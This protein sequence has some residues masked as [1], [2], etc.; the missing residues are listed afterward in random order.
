MAAFGKNEDHRPALIIQICTAR[1]SSGSN[2]SAISLI[3]SIE[4]IFGGVTVVFLG[5]VVHQ[6]KVEMILTCYLL[7]ERVAAIEK[8]IPIAVPVHGKG[9]DA[10]SFRLLNL[11]PQ[12]VGI[13]R[14]I[15]NLNVLGIAKPGLIIGYNFWRAVHRANRSCSRLSTLV[16][17]FPAHS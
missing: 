16:W 17:R 3:K 11:P 10:E 13:L 1:G 8:R 15:S 6:R 9:V 4:R 2:V 14:R 5:F 7:Q 12:N